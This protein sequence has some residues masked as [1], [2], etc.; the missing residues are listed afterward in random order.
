[1]CLKEVSCTDSNGSDYQMRIQ[2]P[3]TSKVL[4]AR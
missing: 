2:F 4:I 3:T 1:M